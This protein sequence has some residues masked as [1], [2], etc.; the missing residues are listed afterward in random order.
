MNKNWLLATFAALWLFDIVLTLIFVNHYGT[1]MEANPV[2]R[3]VLEKGGSIG[4]VVAK[5]AVM[6]PL[7]PFHKRIPKWVYAGLIIVMV[8]VVFGAARIVMWPN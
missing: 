7:V 2:M 5:T 1:S 6:L 3:F 4:F 8:P